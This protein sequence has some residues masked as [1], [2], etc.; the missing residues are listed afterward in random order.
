MI[1]MGMADEA[2]GFFGLLELH[3]IREDM[4]LWLDPLPW[5]DGR[6]KVVFAI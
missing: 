5:L 4:T 6:G 2:N 1:N 3:S